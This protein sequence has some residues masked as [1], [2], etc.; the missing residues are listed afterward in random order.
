MPWV[1]DEFLKLYRDLNASMVMVLESAQNIERHVR[2]IDRRMEE[3]AKSNQDVIAEVRQIRGFV[4]S[5]KGVIEGLR[6]QVSEKLAANEVDDTVVAEID[7]T[8][9][10]AKD[11]AG[12]L[13]QAAV[14][15]P[16]SADPVPPPLPPG[17]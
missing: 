14:T 5:F 16:T 2:R 17:A 13:G 8:F 3:M 12:A 6:Q 11:A 7:A 1:A 10:E 9:T 4:A 15:N